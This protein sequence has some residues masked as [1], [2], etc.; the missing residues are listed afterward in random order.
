[1]I[2]IHNKLTRIV[3]KAELV[4]ASLLGKLEMLQDW[5]RLVAAHII[6]NKSDVCYLKTVDTI[7]R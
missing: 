2:F 3:S 1:M 5:R 6:V 4:K 7:G